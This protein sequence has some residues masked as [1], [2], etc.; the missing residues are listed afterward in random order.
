[1][2][3]DDVV[4]RSDVRAF[5]DALKA[6]TRQPFTAETLPALRQ[7]APQGMAMLEPPIGALAV[8]RSLAMPG[9]A[10]PIPLRLFD[11]RDTREAGPLVLFFHGGGFVIGNI[12]THASMCAE[13]ARQLDL[14]V[15]SV[16]YRLAPEHR[17]P[18]AP[19]DAEAAA[20]WVAESPDALGRSVT[21]LVLCGDSAGANLTI[22]TALALR[23]A[24]TAVPL[25]L[26]LALYPATDP[27]G[28]YPSA[29]AFGDGYGLDAGDMQIYHQLLQPDRSHW[30]ACPVLA[31][32]TGL[33]TSLIVTAGLDPLRDQGRRYAAATIAAGVDTHYLEMAGTI[34]GFAG[35]RR[36][37]PSAQTDFAAV[38]TLARTLILNSMRRHPP[39]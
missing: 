27:G 25:I 11:A 38:L 37:I 23:D 33:P 30:R 32:Q 29:A 31:D 34:H 14:P 21:S 6:H 16:D 22:V 28:D 26:Q 1:M 35:Y 3:M 15:V 12:D 17:W 13:I 18:A 19:D 39:G 20:R 9:P 36:V 7:L 24:P 8:M 10:G 5:L 4:V 2:P